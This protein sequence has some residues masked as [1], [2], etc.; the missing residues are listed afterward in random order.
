MNSP[1]LCGIATHSLQGLPTRTSSDCSLDRWRHDCCCRE[2]LPKSY[3]RRKIFPIFWDIPIQQFFITHIFLTN[4]INRAY[5]FIHIPGSVAF[6]VRLFYYTNTRNRLDEGP[7][8]KDTGKFKGN[9]AG[10]R[11]YEFRWRTMVFCSLLAF[12]IFTIWPCMPPRL[13]SADRSGTATGELARS[14]G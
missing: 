5:S 14:Y 2:T 10:P 8:S 1:R 4:G 12:I 13:L 7:A 9:P 6:Q 11:L 3:C